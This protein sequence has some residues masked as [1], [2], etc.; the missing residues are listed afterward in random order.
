MTQNSN[1][2]GQKEKARNHAGEFPISR[3][4]RHGILALLN[5]SG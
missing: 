3:K 5:I 1:S 4:K 2:Q